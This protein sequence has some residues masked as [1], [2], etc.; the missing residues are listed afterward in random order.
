MKAAAA[1][2]LSEG[3]GGKG[4]GEESEGSGVGSLPLSLHISLSPSILL[5]R[6]SHVV[7][8]SLTLPVSFHIAFRFHPL[9]LAL[10]FASHYLIASVCLW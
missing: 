10:A 8:S 7:L 6:S 5:L 9:P 4:D 3:G 1:K 2:R